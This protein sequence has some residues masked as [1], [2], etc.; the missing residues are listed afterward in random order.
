MPLLPFALFGAAA[1]GSCA[2]AGHFQI[3]S[4]L[5]ND[6]REAQCPRSPGPTYCR[7][8]VLLVQEHVRVQQTAQRRR[9]SPAPRSD[10][11]TLT[12]QLT[13]TISWASMP[14]APAPQ[15]L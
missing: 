8:D 1:T 3:V 4:K 6:E 5:G 11:R 13:P 7:S 2:G 10:A 14:L 12:N 15:M 9:R